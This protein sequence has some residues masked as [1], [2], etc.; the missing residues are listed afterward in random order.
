MTGQRQTSVTKHLVADATDAPD[1][2]ALVWQGRLNLFAPLREGG[3]GRAVR[4]LIT[5]AINVLGIIWAVLAD[6][7]VLADNPLAYVAGIG[8]GALLS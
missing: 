1:R 7:S 6:Q 2:D 8:G 3:P 4:L 5:I